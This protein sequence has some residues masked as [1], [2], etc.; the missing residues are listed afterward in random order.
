MK[1]KKILGTIA[2]RFVAVILAFVMVLLTVVVAVA[3]PLANNYANM[4]S[5][6][7]G[8]TTFTA[9]GG[10]NPQYFTSDYK[11]A[12]EVDKAATE[13]SIQIEREG[14]VLMKNENNALP[15][16]KGAKISLLGQCSV[17]LVY[18]GAGAGSIDTSQVDD[19]KTVLEENDFQVNETLW[20]FYT[21][22]DG[23]AYRKKVPDV[24]GQ[25]G[26]AV[27][28]VP[29]N[30]YSEE[31]LASMKDY[32]DAAIIVVGRSGSE[33]VDLTPDYL[34]FSK[35]EKDLIKYA[36]DN[37]ETVVL[38]LNVTNPMNLSVLNDYA[39]DACLWVGATGQ[40]G[41]YAIG[42][43]LNGTV[44]PSGNTVD[45]WS[46]KPTE[47][48]S[49]VNLG[50][51]TITNSDEF[52]GNKYIVYEEGIYVGYRYYETRYEDVVLGNEK[53]ENFNYDEQVQFPFGYGLSYT[54]F[55]WS[56]YTVTENADSF[57]VSVKVTNTG[58]V[59]GME[60]VQI[61]IQKPYTDYDKANQLEKAAVELVG[62]EK[63]NLLEAG[64]SEV[65]EVVVPKELMKSYDAYG[66]GTYIVEAGNYYLAAGEN[67]HDALNNILAAKSLIVE[68]DAT[69]SS[70]I[71]PIPMNIGNRS[72][73]YTYVQ[74][75]LDTTTYAT[76]HT[77]NTI[78][79]QMEDVDIKAY[80]TEFKYLSRSDWTGTWPTVYAEGQWDAPEALIEALKIVI[81]EDENAQMPAFDVVSEEYGELKLADMIGVPY[82]DP[83]WDA[84]LDQFDKN[85]LYQYIS[86]AGYGT[87]AI[88]DEGVPG[89][90]H[91]D[92]PAGISSTL[93][94]GNINCMGYPP[95]VVLASTWNVD[96]AEARGKLVG[97]DSLSSDVTVW[98]A[99]AMNIHRTAMSGRNFEYYSED[100]F[101]SGVMG[102]AETAAF[103]SKGG[104]VTI[105][106]FAI[107]DQETNR[108]GGAMFCNEQS[109]RELY[110]LPFQMC[111]E[112]GNA[113]GIMSSMNR[114]GGRWIG[115]HEGIMTNILR[116]EW[117][118]EGFVI[119]DQTSFASF[120]YCDIREGLAAGN[121][122]WLCT[123]QDMWQLSDE[124][125]TAT[126]MTNARQA[127]HRYLYVIAN[128][129]AM[130]GVDKDTVVKNV[131]AG[132]QI[133][134]YVIAV[135]ILALD[136]L[137]FMAVRRLWTGMNKAQRLEAKVA[138]RAAK[139]AKKAAKANK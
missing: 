115:G 104:I 128:S 64:A 3:I 21:E 13:L 106:H 12:E 5:M 86:H 92:G 65:V 32:N 42:E 79:N 66:Y 53:V 58:K 125:L 38:M 107:N 60:T 105:K 112:D 74:K 123:G 138:K 1:I 18:G 37:F 9:E 35:E 109:A 117:G 89:V 61:Y 98:Y 7:M 11:S 131:L 88:E 24:T 97:E 23:A 67:A 55:E 71:N 40:E 52:A 136:V 16:A 85:E 50:D 130:N 33:S 100:G 133:A 14:M 122:I 68:G 126:V 46:Y 134:L 36:C 114:V 15:L 80:D 28:E 56:D 43:V 91:K 103:Q 121:D 20:K 25:G 54:T 124:E 41:A 34:E 108:I 139:E 31:A 90:V 95:A 113:W 135:V 81:E 57:T 10:S 93:A 6:F 51:Y 132:W 99:P 44:S 116:D 82:D 45:T 102:A 76:A 8:Q 77:G 49:A 30:V 62:Y 26:F 101:L 111:V 59:A 94:G 47:A 69:T 119:T 17:D 84:Y 2:R 72:M 19:L 137:A 70:Q 29:M 120:A 96:L 110:L 27:N 78:E 75:E 4:V 48:P 22:G 118:Y 73:V 129:N 63:T 87:T 39:I 83:K 127:M